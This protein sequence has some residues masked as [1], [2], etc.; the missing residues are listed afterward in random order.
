VVKMELKAR[1]SWYA[2]HTAR[3]TLE[4]CAKIAKIRPKKRHVP[5]ASSGWRGCQARRGAR[6]GRPPSSP[7]PSGNPP[8]PATLSPAP[9]TGC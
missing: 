6:P 5:L 8:W 1:A 4:T 3:K 7:A 2:Q 9:R